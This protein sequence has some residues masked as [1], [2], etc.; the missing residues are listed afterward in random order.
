MRGTPGATMARPLNAYSADFH[1]YRNAFAKKEYPCR[2][3]VTK[4][5]AWQRGCSRRYYGV[6]VL[7]MRGGNFDQASQ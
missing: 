7:N 4:D 2:K 1:C 6:F 3:A 5:M